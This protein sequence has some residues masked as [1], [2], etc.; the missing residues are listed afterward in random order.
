MVDQA[1]LG[2]HMVWPNPLSNRFTDVQV[3][4]SFWIKNQWS[5]VL[6]ANGT[7]KLRNVGREAA[8][9]FDTTHSKAASKFM[10]PTTIISNFVVASFN[11]SA[12]FGYAGSRIGQSNGRAFMFEGDSGNVD[13]TGFAMNNER[14][15]DTN[16]WACGSKSTVSL[17]IKSAVV[18][19]EMA[20]DIRVAID[21]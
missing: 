10:P 5:F 17:R 9:L 18:N 2:I 6:A 4:P 11:D 21:K 13:V 16:L 12:N 8:I 14:N 20:D 3:H 1:Q 19:Y 15:G 7:G